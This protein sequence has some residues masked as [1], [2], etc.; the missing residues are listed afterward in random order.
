M[1][2]PQTDNE[3]HVSTTI[4]KGLK[5]KENNNKKE[6]VVIEDGGLM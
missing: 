4:P 5:R 3:R 2:T 6:Y 1:C